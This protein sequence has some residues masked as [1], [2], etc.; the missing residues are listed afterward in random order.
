MGT[1]TTLR[2]SATSSGSGWTPSTGTLHGVTSDDSDATYATW[3]GSGSVLILA[4]PADAPPAGERRHQVRLRARGEDGNAWWAVRLPSGALAAGAAALFGSSPETVVGSWGTGAPPDGS[5]VL[6][7]YVTGQTSGVRITELYLDMDSRLAPTFTPQILDGSGAATVTISDT[8]QPTIRADSL[9]LDDLAARQY[10]YWVTLSGAVVWDTGVVSGSPVN[11]DTV[12]LDNGTYVAHLQVWSTLGANTAYASEEETL[13]FT[14]S[15]GAVPVP[16]APSV[17]EESPFYRVEVCAPDVGDF[18]DEAGW[19]EIQRVDCVHAGYLI[20]TGEGYSST[21]SGGASTDLQITVVAGRDDGWFL[22]VD[23]FATLVANWN[24][25]AGQRGW[26]LVIPDDGKPELTW[27]TNG[28]AS[29]GAAATERVRPDPLGV[30]RLRVLLDTDNGAGGWTVT[31][32]TRESDDEE[33]VQLGEST[34]NDGGGTTSIFN[35]PEVYSVGAYFSGSDVVEEFSGKFYSVE[36]R[37]GSAGTILADPDFTG[38]QA[39]TDSFTDGQG[40]LWSVNDPASLTSSQS[41]V[42]IAIVGPLI[43][44]ECV[45]WVDFTFPRSGVAGTCDYQPEE[46]CSYYRV[47]TLVLMDGQL[48]VSDWN[49]DSGPE[50]FCLEWSEDEHLIRSTSSDGPIYAV[51]SGKFDWSVPRPFTSA[52]GVM[53]SRFVTSAPPGGR[54]LGM[55]AAVNDE[56]ELTELRAVLARP[57]VLISP[58][59]ASEVWA[60]PVQESVRVV[61]VG[62]IRQ[63]TAAFIGTGPEPSPQTADVGI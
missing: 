17:T 38:H 50:L 6:S 42:T 47:R 10:R 1:V 48:L 5:I 37:D 8:A 46:C 55:A 35:S 16:D 59:D 7:A 57:L 49:S 54:N 44:D 26:H 25:T 30:V 14:V 36:I 4:T 2:P 18:D 51:V 20:T 3:S 56:E 39:G 19:L 60:A 21:P 40:N 29:L 43:T 13:E 41:A 58:S 52:L 53:G 62:R 61:K 9:D 63:V 31:F 15:V 45:E 24:Q 12:P 33:W 27:S 28:T 22:D 32:Y 34:S 23:T 11:R